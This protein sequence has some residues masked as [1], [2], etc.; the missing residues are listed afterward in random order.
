MAWIKRNFFENNFQDRQE[1]VS[2]IQS[3]FHLQTALHL[4][5]TRQGDS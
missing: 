3:V 5:I 2:P 4:I 1:L